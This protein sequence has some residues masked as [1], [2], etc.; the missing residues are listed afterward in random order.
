MTL[1][2]K[3]C[4]NEPRL[5]ARQRTQTPTCTRGLQG[6]AQTP[7]SPR[8]VSCPRKGAWNLPET[9][10]SVG[11]D[12]ALGSRPAPWLQQTPRTLRPGKAS[13]AQRTPPAAAA[14]GAGV[15]EQGLPASRHPRA[16]SPAPSPVAWCHLVTGG[17][18]A[19]APAGPPRPPQARLPPHRTGPA[20]RAGPAGP[21]LPRRRPPA[22][23]SR[24]PQLLL[25]GKPVRRQPKRHAG[26]AVKIKGKGPDLPFQGEKSAG[27]AFPQKLGRQ[28]RRAKPTRDTVSSRKSTRLGNSPRN[29]L[30][31]RLTTLGTVTDCKS[32]SENSKLRLTNLTNYKSIWPRIEAGDTSDGSVGA[33]EGNRGVYAYTALAVPVS[34]SETNCPTQVFLTRI[35]ERFCGMLSD[36]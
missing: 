34:F 27:L 6:A 35:H 11:W 28:G 18:T 24:A 13:L 29:A 21:P 33:G 26:A 25:G 14:A 4:P 30:A 16:A 12:R 3:Y 7:N 9:V 1:M 15:P 8:S 17:R 20:A 5:V 22:R 31:P 23:P 32:Q 10:G 19:T 2:A 36:T